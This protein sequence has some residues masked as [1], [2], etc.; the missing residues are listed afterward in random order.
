MTDKYI[1][2]YKNLC[3]NYN[4]EV[5][6]YGTFDGNCIKEKCFTY[7]L[8]QQL[9]DKEQETKKITKSYKNEIRIL[10]ET[11]EIL[12]KEIVYLKKELDRK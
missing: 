1:I 10:Q 5:G 12:C 7:K 9:Q 3:K 4:K 11:N 8:L 2:D 6:C